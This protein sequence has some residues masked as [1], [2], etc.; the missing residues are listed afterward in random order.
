MSASADTGDTARLNLAGT[1]TERRPPSPDDTTDLG[2]D[3]LADAPDTRQV[4]LEIRRFAEGIIRFYR[5]RTILARGMSDEL[6][7]L[8]WSYLEQLDPGE[9]P[10]VARP[11]FFDLV[12]FMRLQTLGDGFDHPG[13]RRRVLDV[14][15]TLD[16]FLDDIFARADANRGFPDAQD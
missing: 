5:A 7:G 13:F 14:A 2:T 16:G 3:F 6:S 10:G 1:P 15:M 4:E 9:V 11:A 8:A 12:Y